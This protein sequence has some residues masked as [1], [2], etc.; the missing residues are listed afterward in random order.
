[1]DNNKATE[2]IKVLNRIADALEANN[3]PVVDKKKIQQEQRMHELEEKLK[4]LQISKLMTE[5]SHNTDP[6]I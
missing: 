6:T 3:K 2:L 4:M 5:R 1:M